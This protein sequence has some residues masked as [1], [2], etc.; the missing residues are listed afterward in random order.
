MSYLHPSAIVVP[1]LREVRFVDPELPHITR[2]FSFEQLRLFHEHE[3]AL[4]Q[5]RFQPNEHSIPGGFDEFRRL[6]N[7]GGPAD[8]YFFTSYD[9]TTGQ[10]P[11]HGRLIPIAELIPG[12]TGAATHSTHDHNITDLLWLNAENSIRE[13]RRQDRAK[14][15]RLERRAHNQHQTLINGGDTYTEKGDTANSSSNADSVTT[16]TTQETSATSTGEASSMAVDT[17]E[18]VAN[19]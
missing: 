3:A 5:H 9:P 18:D 6:W 15:R 1:G 4:R 17:R 14:R 10:A 19:N 16:V 13:R 7:E 2:A 11:I 12:W 8:D